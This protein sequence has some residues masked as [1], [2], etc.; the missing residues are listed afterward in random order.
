MSV[1][2]NCEFFARSVYNYRQQNPTDTATIAS[3]VA[4]G[5]LALAEAVDSVQVSLWVSKTGNAQHLDNK[6]INCVTQNVIV[7]LYKQPQANQLQK[8]YRDAVVTCS[9]SP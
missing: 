3:L 1:V 7:T 8:F 6:V 5:K 2:F 4:G 9:K